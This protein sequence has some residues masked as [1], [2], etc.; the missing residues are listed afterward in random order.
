M[1]LQI[2]FTAI[3]IFYAMA[4]VFVTKSTYGLMKKG[5]FEDMVAVYYN[6]KIVHMAAGG[7]V[8]IAVPFM[9][10]TWIYPLIIG[11]VLTVFTVAPRLKGQSMNF[12]QTKENWNDSKFTL[13]WGISIAIMWILFKDP[14]LAVIPTLFMAFGDAVTGVIRNALYKKRTKSPVGNVFMLIVCIVIGYLFTS[15]AHNPIPLWGVIAAVGASI[16]ERYE[17]GPIDDNVLITVTTMII[18]SIGILVG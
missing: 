18:L 13:M 11:L 9:F 15:L 1:Y 7:V 16:V 17:V 12:M 4:I 6:R 10:D 14:F 2:V 5:G 3:S 8:A